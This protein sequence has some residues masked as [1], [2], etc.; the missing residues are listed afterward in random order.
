MIIILFKMKGNKIKSLERI[1]E[2]ASQ[3]KSIY[4]DYGLK[5]DHQVTPAAFIQNYPFRSVVSMFN[6]GRFYEYKKK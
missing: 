4:I 3:R 5:M 6:A 1:I 2:L